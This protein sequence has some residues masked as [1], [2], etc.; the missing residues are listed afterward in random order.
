MITE[1]K[2][3]PFRSVTF[4]MLMIEEKKLKRGLQNVSTY[5]RYFK[6]ISSQIED[7]RPTTFLNYVSKY[8]LY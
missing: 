1:K 3:K 2:K 6:V 5:C 8:P 4:N 7:G